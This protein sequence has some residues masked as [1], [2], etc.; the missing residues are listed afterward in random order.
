V[1]FFHKLEKNSCF[2]PVFLERQFGGGDGFSILK[3]TF[4][5]SLLYDKQTLQVSLGVLEENFK[6]I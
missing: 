1:R 3:T 2:L 5:Y 4:S 6:D